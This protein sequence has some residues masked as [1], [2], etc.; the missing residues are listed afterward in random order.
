[1]NLSV[2][3]SYI[4]HIS[5]CIRPIWQHA[6]YTSP[7]ESERFLYDKFHRASISDH[8][9]VCESCTG[10]GLIQNAQFENLMLIPAL[11][12]SPVS[13]LSTCIYIMLCKNICRVACFNRKKPRF[14]GLWNPRSLL[15]CGSEF[16]E[17][18]LLVTLFDVWKHI[19]QVLMDLKLK[20]LTITWV[21]VK[22]FC[23]RIAWYLLNLKKKD[24][25]LFTPTYM[26]FGKFPLCLRH[27][28]NW[29][30]LVTSWN[31]VYATETHLLSVS[32]VANN[33]KSFPI[34]LLSQVML[35][36]WWRFNVLTTHMPMGRNIL[37][38]LSEKSTKLFD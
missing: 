13:F 14:V 30:D 10:D 37:T 12:E 8:G 22:P 31:M 16:Y 17:R 29:F 11:Q 28:Q 15:T 3:R 26:N 20:I 35:T 7:T 19:L 1:M 5:E 38:V 6:T 34:L 18:V 36:D 23:W 25:F 2:K 9:Q 33:D 21:L 27:K 24:V 32:N 4:T